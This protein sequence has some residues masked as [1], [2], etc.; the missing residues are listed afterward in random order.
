MTNIRNGGKTPVAG[1]VHAIVMLL[2]ML[3]LANLAKLIPLSALAGVLV[4]VAYNMSEWRSFK[5]ILKSA[6]GEAAVLLT[7]FLLTIFIGLS[8]ALPFGIILAMVLF[9]NRVMETT[10]IAVLK[11][12]VEDEQSHVSDGFETLIIPKGVEVFQIRGPFFFGIANKFEEAEKEIH[13]A[14]LVRIIRMRR[15]PFIDS[16]GLRNLRSFVERS[17]KHNTT[18]ILSGVIP[19]AMEQIKKE[20]LLAEIGDANICENIE[21][22]LDR[23]R[24]LLQKK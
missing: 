6:R 24:E 12:E 11:H 20:G 22:A 4:V 13:E 9:I 2:L 8:F 23:S 3:F 10:D 19:K 17:K 16:T 18:I 15:V 21:K 14:P 7:T 5:N 1:M